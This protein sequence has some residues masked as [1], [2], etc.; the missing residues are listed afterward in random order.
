MINETKFMNLLNR[1]FESNEIM[2]NLQI[3][4]TTF[5]I[6][7]N[8]TLGPDVEIE[9]SGETSPTPALS[10]CVLDSEAGFQLSLNSAQSVTA[11]L[12]KQM[13][14]NTNVEEQQ[15]FSFTF[16]PGE[17]GVWQISSLVTPDF[18]GGEYFITLIPAD[19]SNGSNAFYSLNVTSAPSTFVVHIGSLFV[20]I[21]IRYISENRLTKI[22]AIL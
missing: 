9:Y 16:V 17:Q 8:N 19:C 4:L 15:S 6:L 2:K 20:V 1:N 10:V 5:I 18:T 11:V 22:F 7:A 3:N 12:T 14:A 13:P 21:D